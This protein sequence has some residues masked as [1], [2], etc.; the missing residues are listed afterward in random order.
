MLQQLQEMP[1][2]YRDAA[3]VGVELL[4]V[5]VVLIILRFVIGSVFRRLG[6]SPRAEKHAALLTTIL[7]NLT[8]L[9]ILIFV[10]AVIALAAVNGY[11][12]YRGS[13]IYAETAGWLSRIPPGFFAA[14]GLGLIK[15]LALVIV[16]TVAVRL[17]R[18]L[19]V[20][21]SA[22]S[23]API[24]SKRMTKVLE[25]SSK[26]S[27]QSLE[28][29]LASRARLHRALAA[30]ASGDRRLRLPR[31]P[32]L[33]DHLDRAP[34]REGRRGNRRHAGRAHHALRQPR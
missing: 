22:A 13:G 9:L 6:R 11:A 5:A 7:R 24:A 33:P 26:G 4:I 10:V 21:C 31:A 18:R 12:A 8:A 1:P 32:R 3:V 20:G 17:V 34:R 28:R 23:N 30:G 14:L 2:A 27:A 15:A 29:H 19:L 16:A 25:R